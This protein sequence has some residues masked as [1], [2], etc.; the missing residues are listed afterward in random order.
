MGKDPR[1]PKLRE[2]LKHHLE[3]GTFPGAILAVVEGDRIL[4]EG[5]G[6]W[7]VLEP[8]RIAVNRETTFDISS[9]TKPLATGLLAILL[10]QDGILQL[11]D[12]V[13]EY[14][15]GF[16]G[17]GRDEVQV[18]DLLLHRSGLPAWVPLYLGG[19]GR[20][21]MIQ[22]LVCLP[23]ACPPRSQVIYSCPGFILLGE[24]LRS[25]AGKDLDALFSERIAIPLGLQDTHFRPPPEMLR[26]CAATERGAG[27]ERSMAG[28]TGSSFSGWRE[29]IIWGEVHDGNAHG[30][31]GVSGNAGLFSTAPDLLKLGREFLES[32]T[33]L[34]P[35][36]WR[37]EFRRNWTE[38]RGEARSPG[39]QLAETIGSA[40]F[41][42]LPGESFGHTGFTGVSLWIQPDRNRVY[43]FLTNRIHPEAKRV[44]M[45][46]VRREFHRLAGTMSS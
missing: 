1:T 10:S 16:S 12:S 36:S 38:N 41:G 17:E 4:D 33:G 9:L 43:L 20:L 29:G 11:S 5:W 13:K 42:T 25:A 19:G 34:I 24:V 28:K 26:R 15:P 30:M 45:N 7:A 23:L 27:W 8:E 46:A 3:V 21:E 31:G 22:R 44:D 35:S 39:W 6:G 18:V 32:G 14:V 37:E 40:G 2:F